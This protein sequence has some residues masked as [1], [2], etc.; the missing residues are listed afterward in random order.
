MSDTELLEVVR[1]EFRAQRE[2]TL[3][4]ADNHETRIRAL[5]RKSDLRSAVVS[6]F[7]AVAIGFASALSGCSFL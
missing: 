7:T 6:A 1:E 3:Q 2:L 4:L 5:E